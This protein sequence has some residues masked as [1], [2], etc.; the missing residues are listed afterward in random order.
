M[1][2]SDGKLTVAISVIAVRKWPDHK[3]EMVNQLL[4]GDF[5]EIIDTSGSW[6]CVR[7]LEDQYQGWIENRPEYLLERAYTE[8]KQ[9]IVSATAGVEIS[10]RK[11][12]IPMGSYLHF[13]ECKLYMGKASSEVS[14]MES[15]QWIKAAFEGVPYLWGGKTIF[16]ID[17][18]GLVQ[19]YARLAGIA[20]P[21]DA[22][23]QALQGDDMILDQQLPGDLV[24]FDGNHGTKVNHVGII[25][26]P[27][28]IL[29]ASGH[30][31]VDSFDFQGIWDLNK[32]AYTHKYLFT[33][34]ITRPG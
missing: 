23:D 27:G 25:I 7:S 22:K 29:H 18:S 10:N 3:S 26:E 31:R 13:S 5:I 33:K 20:L 2:V 32:Q 12:N 6:I 34:R 28:K 24:F 21:R 11:L 8:M 15:L 17:C 19:L 9:I 30:V 14:L 4:F 1:K 16:G